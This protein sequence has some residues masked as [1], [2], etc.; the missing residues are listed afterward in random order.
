MNTYL[1][2]PTLEPEPLE[3]PLLEPEGTSIPEPQPANSGRFAEEQIG[4]LVRQ[5]FCPGWPKPAR[6]VVF[7]A[8]DEK[9][10]IAE[11]C[12]DIGRALAEQVSGSVCVVEANPHNPEIEEIFSR[13]VPKAPHFG[14]LRNCQ[15]IAGK[16]WLAK[17]QLLCGENG[18]GISAPGLERA[19]A[20]L[21]REF[22]YTLLHAPPAGRYSETA[23]LG[24]VSD[25][26]VLVL[27]AHSTRRVTAQKAKTVLQ[28]ANARVLGVVLSE[29]TFPIPEAI[30]R[31][32]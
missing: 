21:R 4:Q 20:D 32:L 22:D 19:L 27:E 16:L 26:V 24:H 18:N 29:R 3:P 8:V 9:T 31:K 23:L 6:H 7:S 15:H 5:V 30:Y 14:P 13:K 25:G 17:S 10:Y 28:A 1:R 2:P 12:M 11:I